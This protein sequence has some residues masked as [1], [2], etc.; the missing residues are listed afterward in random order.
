MALV[1]PRTKQ[2][3]TQQLSGYTDVLNRI[4]VSTKDEQEAGYQ[5]VLK[6]E[7]ASIGNNKP[8]SVS[9]R[10]HTDPE[11]PNAGNMRINLSRNPEHIGVKPNISMSVPEKGH[12]MKKMDG[13]LYKYRLVPNGEMVDA[14]HEHK[15][16]R[17]GRDKDTTKRIFKDR[18]TNQFSDLTGEDRYEEEDTYE[19]V[20]ARP[21]MGLPVTRDGRLRADA[22]SA[23]G[24]GDERFNRFLDEI[25]GR[26]S[27][28][29]R[30]NVAAEVAS[31][32][33]QNPRRVRFNN[34]RNQANRALTTVL[35]S[36][37][38]DSQA[39]DIESGSVTRPTQR[40]RRQSHPPAS[41]EI[42][43]SLERQLK[44]IED[45][46]RTP[47]TPPHPRTSAERER[48][49]SSVEQRV[50]SMG[51]GEEERKSQES[52]DILRQR[53][54]P[55]KQ[56]P[57]KVLFQTPSDETGGEMGG[58]ADQTAGRLTRA[59]NVIGN[60][61]DPEQLNNLESAI[62]SNDRQSLERIRGIGSVTASILLSEDPDEQRIIMKSIKNRRETISPPRP[63]RSSESGVDRTRR[64]H[65]FDE[66]LS[67]NLRHHTTGEPYTLE[68]LKGLT[69]RSLQSILSRK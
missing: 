23:S 1:L 3:P 39:D 52:E 58:A 10:K 66:I 28:E 19:P 2:L 45:M 47:Q 59:N 50:Q 41:T 9:L 63:S 33:G 7:D 44:R 43:T 12:F 20:T 34:R 32:A 69:T 36:Q 21:A 35:Q 30:R 40:Q 55:P 68:Q 61:S 26:P 60:I 15:G 46:G 22:I 65:L 31:V 53:R 29:S 8:V 24:I 62:R 5:N 38:T 49:L 42:I 13:D 17:F 51:G 56:T 27:R 57:K 16:D 48:L 54:S 64:Y 4:M 25:V 67:R 6:K 11:A 37:Q 14:W 18:Q